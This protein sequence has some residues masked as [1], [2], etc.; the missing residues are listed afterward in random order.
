MQ[1]RLND[2]LSLSAEEQYLRLIETC[3][4]IPQRVPQNMIASFLG[5]KRETLSRI[6]KNN[7]PH[8]TKCEICYMDQLS[9]VDGLPP[10]LP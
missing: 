8:E 7:F 9:Q 2:K 3:D 6:R 5:I 4:S 1:R 10:C